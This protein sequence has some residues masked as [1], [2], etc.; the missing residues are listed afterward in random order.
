MILQRICH[1]NELI[2]ILHNTEENKNY[3]LEFKDENEFIKI[4]TITIFIGDDIMWKSDPSSLIKISEN[5][6][7][8]PIN[9]LLE[10]Y[11]KIYNTNIYDICNN[12]ISNISMLVQSTQP[13]RY[14]LEFQ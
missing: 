1:N 6:V 2:R 10:N 4:D 11:K 13:I 12:N 8:L 5:K 14:N 9:L 7:L 3:L